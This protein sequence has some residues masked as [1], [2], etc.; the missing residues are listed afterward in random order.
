MNTRNFTSR[1]FLAHWMLNSLLIWPSSLMLCIFLWWPV[2]LILRLF[3]LDIETH[4]I[5]SL[6]IN[7]I[8]LIIP[9]LLVGYI[10][11][12]FQKILAHDDLGWYLSDWLKYSAIGGFLGGLVIVLLLY[13]P[14]TSTRSWMMAMPI[15]MGILS[16]FQWLKMRQMVHD[17]WL[18]ILA[19]LSAGCVFSGL[20]FMNHPTI[21]NEPLMSF[22]LWIFATLAQGLIT[23]IVLLCLYE[24]PIID[25]AELAPVY[26]EIRDE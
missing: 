9:G 2:A 23:G 19:N 3:G 8:R 20:L 13:V 15:F 5:F 21:H 22:A 26:L 14:P 1:N 11:G 10:I 18:W 7:F 4:S 25:E 6:I 12:G 17:A 16:S 24:R